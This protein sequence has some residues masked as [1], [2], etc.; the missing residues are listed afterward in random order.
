MNTKRFP[1][2][3]L[4]VC[5]LIPPVGYLFTLSTVED[6][7]EKRE[8]RVIEERLIQNQQALLDGR[9]SVR[10]EIRRNLSRYFSRDLKTKMGVRTRVLV[11]SRDQQVLYP[12]PIEEEMAGG[13]AFTASEE[14]GPERL[15]YVDLAAENFQ[16]LNQGFE[17]G[18]DVEILHNGWLSNGVLLGWVLLSGALLHA[19]I[20]RR[21]QAV[22]RDRIERERHIASLSEQLDRARSLAREVEEKEADYHRR[23]QAL[24]HERDSLSQ[25]AEGL[26]EEMDQLEQNANQQKDLREETELEILELRE[27]VERL[28]SRTRKSRK[29]ET[30]TDRLRKRLNVLYKN[31]DFTDRAVEGM[32]DLPPEARL[33]AE[34]VMQL[35]N[36]DPSQVAVKRNVFGKGGKSRVLESEFAYAGRLYFHRRN[37]RCARIVAVGTKNTQTKD[38]AYLETYTSTSREA[39]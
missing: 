30:E 4:F 29:K 8:T 34:E 27:E 35:L 32:A 36:T 22:E 37:G 13:E 15:H 38:L 9:Y 24:E 18:V 5:L 21:T 2:R 12:V 20:R 10:E 39:S 25:D 23:I 28:R 3:I 11:K 33:K 31:L 17:V 16:L 7:L 26:L 1:F 19:V 6:T 14:G